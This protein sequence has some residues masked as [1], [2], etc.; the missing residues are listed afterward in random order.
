MSSLQVLPGAPLLIPPAQGPKPRYKFPLGWFD[1]TKELG[2]YKIRRSNILCTDVYTYHVWV[3][4]RSGRDFSHGGS[5]ITTLDIIS[6]KT[7]KSI[8]HNWYYELRSQEIPEHI[9]A[10]PYG[11][12]R[13]AALRTFWAMLDTRAYRIIELMFPETKGRGIRDD[14]E[15][16]LTA[17][18]IEE[19]V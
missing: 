11:P 15:I 17:K 2:R 7:G 4:S 16:V 18:Q 8:G 14:G 1:S 19:A 13:S 9:D 3:R 6:E 5:T 10:L 12:E